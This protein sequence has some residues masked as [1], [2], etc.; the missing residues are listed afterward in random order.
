MDLPL[1][2]HEFYHQGFLLH[3]FDENDLNIGFFSQQAFGKLC[4]NLGRWHLAHRG[5]RVW[6]I[7]LNQPRGL[8]KFVSEMEH[9]S[10]VHMVVHSRSAAVSAELL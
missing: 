7:K 9:D 8:S 4:Q 3:S 2:K 10:F 5:A 6:S 1:E